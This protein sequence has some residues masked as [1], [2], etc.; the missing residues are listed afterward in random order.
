MSDRWRAFGWDVHDVDGHD[1]TG[2]VRTIQALDSAGPPHV[3]LARTV[4]GK[5]VSYMEGLVRWHYMPMSD[6]EFAQALAE[7]D[8]P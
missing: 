3:L 4:F 5:G 2:M 7:I 6:D 1:S 8:T